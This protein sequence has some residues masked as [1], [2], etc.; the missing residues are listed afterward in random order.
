MKAILTRDSP[1]F[2]HVQAKWPQT[3]AS[4]FLAKLYVDAFADMCIEFVL[5]EG[6]AKLG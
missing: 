1:F 5:T 4:Y 6:I 2:S 3:F